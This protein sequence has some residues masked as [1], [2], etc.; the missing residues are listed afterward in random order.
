MKVKIMKIK[1]IVLLFLA[2]NSQLLLSQNYLYGWSTEGDDAFIGTEQR[3]YPQQIGADSDWKSLKAGGKNVAAIKTDGSLWMWG[4]NNNYQMGIGYDIEF[5]PIPVQVGTSTDWEN[6]FCGETHTAAI[7]ND[8]SL[9]AWGYNSKGQL[10]IGT[11]SYQESVPVRV[12]LENNWASITNA[13]DFTVGLKKDSSL[14]G[15]GNEVYDKY[16]TGQL[17]SSNVPILLDS[18]LN[19]I[20]T[21]QIIVK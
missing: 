14:W 15:R 6:V 16:G 18:T 20:S 12:G 21:A 19:K 9:W 7:R 1:L 10:G 13:S 3:N 5:Q 4:S 11:W 17:I 2:V 8:G